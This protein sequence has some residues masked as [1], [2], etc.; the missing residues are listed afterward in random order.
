MAGRSRLD[1][2]GMKAR[3]PGFAV[4]ALAVLSLVLLTSNLLSPA[5]ARARRLTGHLPAVLPTQ[6]YA[7]RRP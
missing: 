3:R 7:R 5:T 2:E 4:R 6:G 1:L